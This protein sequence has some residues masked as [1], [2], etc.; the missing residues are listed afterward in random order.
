MLSL[1]HIENIAVIERAD[2]EFENGLTVLTG[3]TGAGKSIII[4]SI[5]AIMVQRTSRELI[6]AGSSKGFVSA[7]FS[8]IP[9]ELTNWLQ[10]NELDGEE[11]DTVHVQRQISADGK[12]ICRVN[13]RPVSVSVL[14][15]I[16]PFLINIHGQHDGQKLMDDSCHID[17]LDCFAGLQNSLDEYV[18]LYRKLLS[19]KERI[20]ELDRSEQERL[21][22]LDMLTF[23]LDEIDSAELIDGEEEQLEK[24][25]AFFDNVG[26]LA[27]A[28][29]EA[30]NALDGDENL[31]RM[32]AYD[33]LCLTA[34]ALAGL[35]DVSEELRSLSER[36]EELKYLALDLRDSVA[37]QQMQTDFSPEEREAV[38]DRLD[39]IYRL[40]QKYGSTISEILEY[41]QHAREELETLQTADERREDLLNEYKTVRTQAREYANVLSTARKTAAAKLEKCIV[42]ELSDLDMTKVRL[43]VRVETGSKL[44]AKGIDAV[45]F[46]ISVNPGETLRPLSKV[47]SGGEL[48]RVMLAMKNVLTAQEPVGTLIFDEIDTGVSGRAAQKIA[49]KLSEIGLKKQTLCVTHLPQ[50]AAMGDYHML[51]TKSVQNDRTYTEVRQVTGKARTEEIARMISGDQITEA[52]LANASELLHDAKAGGLNRNDYYS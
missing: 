11:T 43:A 5:G 37:Q 3:E 30:Y 49:H 21:Q 12:S 8:S 45:S 35:T 33:L 42:A 48:S 9:P 20:N 47:A 25:K 2:I 16:S 27:N 40:K 13:T 23:H 1:L 7:V 14:K 29:H 10:E 50:I 52:S 38:E 17:F 15:K 4:D 19:L 39:T 32:G 6:R 51:I 18:P 36:A 31:D 34:N 28:L 24:R 26:R 41:A 44:T 46:L 22:R